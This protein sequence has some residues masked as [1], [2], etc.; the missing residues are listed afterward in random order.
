M[1][2]LVMRIKAAVNSNGF[3]ALLPCNEYTEKEKYQFLLAK[4]AQPILAQTRRS[5]ISVIGCHLLSSSED[6][7]NPARL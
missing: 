7:V 2:G 1:W 6:S 4:F 5:F 3:C